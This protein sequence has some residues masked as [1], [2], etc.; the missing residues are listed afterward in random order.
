MSDMGNA[1]KIPRKRGPK[2]TSQFAA[3]SPPQDSFTVRDLNRQPAKVLG[4]CDQ[5]GSVRIRT[6]AG[7]SYVLRR[8]EPE[9]SRIKSLPDME[10]HRKRLRE[11]GY[12]PPAAHEM[13]RIN[14]IIAGEV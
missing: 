8:E 10:A 12:V 2:A 6:R 4:A 11:L 5:H 1:L 7:A 9:R 3:G 13:E 14:Q